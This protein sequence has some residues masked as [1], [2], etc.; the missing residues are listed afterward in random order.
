MDV[1]DIVIWFSGIVAVCVVLWAIL[2][3]RAWNQVD[4]K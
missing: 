2:A 3:I 1:N 4:R